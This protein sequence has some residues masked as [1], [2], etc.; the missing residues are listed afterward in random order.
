MDVEEF[1]LIL[2]D[3]FQT[4]ICYPKH[5]GKMKKEYE[6]VCYTQWAIN[7]IV[8]HTIKYLYP[9]QRGSINDFI[10]SVVDFAIKMECYE[11]L[12]RNNEFMFRTA[13]QTAFSVRELLEA[14]K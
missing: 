12:N 5:A 11:M 10:S 14:M 1:K 7:K 3:V 13:K 6:K 9:Y 4:D 2:K 8:E